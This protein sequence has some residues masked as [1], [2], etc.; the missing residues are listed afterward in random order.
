[1]LRKAINRLNRKT[2]GHDLTPQKDMR[3]RNRMI[4]ILLLPAAILLWLIG[5]ILSSSPAPSRT[6][7]RDIRESA[8]LVA[9]T[10]EEE[11]PE[12]LQTQPR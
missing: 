7:T 8:K 9:T 3:T 5:W 10:L 11:K 12:I 1:M 4:I 2:N 6:E